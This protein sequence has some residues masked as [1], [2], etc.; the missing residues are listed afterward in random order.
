M[1]VGVWRHACCVARPRPPALP[2]WRQSHAA[3][4]ARAPMHCAAPAQVFLLC[5]SAELENVASLSIKPGAS[6]CLNVRACLSGGAVPRRTVH[7]HCARLAPRTYA[8]MHAG[9][10]HAG[11]RVRGC[12]GPRERA[13]E[14]PRGPG[15]PQQQG[16]CALLHEVCQGAGGCAHQ[17]PWA[18]AWGRAHERACAATCACTRGAACRVQ[19]AWPARAHTPPR[20]CRPH[21]G[22]Q[23]P[24]HG[25]HHGHQGRDARPDGCVHACAGLPAHAARTS[26]QPLQPT[27]PHVHV[28]ACNSS[29]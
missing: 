9:Q 26:H 14:Q 18:T 7:C 22:E 27:P 21:T 3:K 29:S 23:E 1:P 12:G 16:H 5:I 4:R 15:A 13:R 2:A 11:A 25:Q 20:R 10:T 6:F 17:P 24:R 8:R 19:G 28:P